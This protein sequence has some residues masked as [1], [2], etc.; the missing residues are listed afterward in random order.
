MGDVHDEGLGVAVRVDHPVPARAG[1][2]GDAG[3]GAHSAAEDV[4]Q[5]LQVLLGP[6]AAGGVGRRVGPRPAGRREE[7]LGDRVDHFAPGGEQPD[8]RPLAH[9]RPG[10]RAGFQD[11]GFDAPV[12]EVG[13]GGQADGAGSD[14]DDGQLGGGGRVHGGSLRV[15]TS[16]DGLGGPAWHLY[17]RTST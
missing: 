15:S 13:G 1:D 9:R 11:E 17:R 6:V 5:G 3:A 8:V 10:G 12:D 14:H 2:A 7:L 16:V 4:G